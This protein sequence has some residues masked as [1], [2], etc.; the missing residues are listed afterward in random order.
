MPEKISINLHGPEQ[1]IKMATGLDIAV[2]SELEPCTQGF[3]IF[4]RPGENVFF[5]DT[6][7]FHTEPEADALKSL[8]KWLQTTCVYPITRDVNNYLNKPTLR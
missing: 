2:G 3:G 6:P 5:V 7:G 1:F 4:N 8:S